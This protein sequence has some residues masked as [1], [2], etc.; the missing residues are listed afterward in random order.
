MPLLPHGYGLGPDGE[1]YVSWR[2][3][4]EG[5]LRDIVVAR[6]DD[7]GRSFGVPRRVHEDGWV[8]D[9]CPH[10]G[11]SLA[12]DPRGTLHVAWYTGLE[13][14]PGL[15]YASSADRAETFTEPTT[16]LSGPWVPPSQVS[17]DVDASG[18]VLLA[19]EDRRAETATFRLASMRQGG[20]IE[21]G[22]A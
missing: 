13:D 19:W 8:L 22:G 14:G 18:T 12:V 5:S 11:P 10:A 2:K 7:G 15:F 17:L 9:G 4:F 1:I 6:S 21:P 3:V 20:D 16:L